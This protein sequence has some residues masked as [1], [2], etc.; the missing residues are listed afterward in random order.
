[1][2]VGL[3]KR[4]EYYLIEFKKFLVKYERKRKWHLFLHTYQNKHKRQKKVHQNPYAG[5]MRQERGL[6]SSPYPPRGTT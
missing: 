2:V 3:H 4:K 1:M 5:V 6:K